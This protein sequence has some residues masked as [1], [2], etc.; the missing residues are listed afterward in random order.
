MA[1]FEWK[2]RLLDIFAATV[3]QQT[4]EEAAEDMASLSFCYPSLHEDYLRTFDFAIEA[5]QSGDNYPVECVNRS[6]YKAHGAED[7][8]ELVEDLKEI[9]MRIF[10]AGK[11]K[12][13]QHEGN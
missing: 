5:L 12:G 10:M 8:L 11:V 7:A 3:N 13:S 1:S 6:G 4:L 9:Y 2:E